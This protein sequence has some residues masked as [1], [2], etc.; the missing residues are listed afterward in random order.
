MDNITLEHLLSRRSIRKYEDRRL[1]KEQ[2]TMLLQAAMNAPSAC[3]QQCWHFIVIEDRKKLNELSEI[4]GGYHTLKNAP[5]AILVCSEPGTAKLECFVDQDCAAATEN[6]LIAAEALGLGALW[7]GVNQTSPGDSVIIRNVLN[8]PE[9]IK[10]FSFVALGYPTEPA[11]L[12]NKYDESK[13][14]Y[15]T[16]LT[17]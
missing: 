4:H 3:N 6:I 13:I 14:H 8:I 1:S 7:M 16:F 2:V 10:P 9:E 11:P 15:D 5:L 12:Q 17:A